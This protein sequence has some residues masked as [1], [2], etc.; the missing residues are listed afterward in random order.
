MK[1]HGPYFWL[2]VW[3]YKN[4]RP[5]NTKLLMTLVVLSSIV[6]AFI[7]KPFDA[8]SIM[9]LGVISG[10]VRMLEKYL[11]GTRI[12]LQSAGKDPLIAERRGI[13]PGEEPA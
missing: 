11:T 8:A 4:N 12:N 7:G 9:I 2:D 6:L 10:G 1:L 3:D 13:E 5:D